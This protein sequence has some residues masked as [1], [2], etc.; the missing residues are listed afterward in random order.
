MRT[1][2]YIQVVGL[3]NQTAMNLAADDAGGELD[4]HGADLLGNPLGGLV[5]STGFGL[6][7][8]SLL[9]NATL[10]AGNT[11]LYPNATTF[12]G[13]T[14]NVTSLNGTLANYT[15]TESW[16][17]FVGGN[18][19]CFKLCDPSYNTTANYCQK[20]ATCLDSADMQ[21]LRSYRMFL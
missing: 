16:N 8:S 11:T 1:A 17:S 13:T 14:Y 20:Y 19:F 5:Y 10:A 2:A 4:P 9:S 12:N 21:Y 6:Y 15:Q 7:N 3:Y 18:V